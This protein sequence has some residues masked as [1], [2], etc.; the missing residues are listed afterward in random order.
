MGDRVR[1]RVVG[2]LFILASVAAIAGGSLVL[3]VDKGAGLGEI[4]SSD[5]R[6][7]TGVL[8]E[9]VMVYAVLGIATLFFPVLRRSDGGLAMGYVAART[10]EAVL[11]LVAA[12]SALVV[13]AASRSTA[14]VDGA[15]LDA[16]VLVRE[17]T[18]MLGSLVALGLGG[19]VLYTLLLR[20]GIVP[21]WLAV[22]GLAGAA[23]ILARGVVG[24]YGADLSG[25]AQAVLAAPIALNEMVLAVWLIV[26]GFGPPVDAPI[27]EVR[28]A[29]PASLP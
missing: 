5:A 9:L 20:S 10:M 2:S 8:L 1:A 29:V 22:W 27:D 23:L 7:V 15:V 16:M 17:W 19:L 25:L 12:T 6:I 14:A 13:V 26:R 21:G 18:Y 24:M 28:H 3:P 11:L 4:A